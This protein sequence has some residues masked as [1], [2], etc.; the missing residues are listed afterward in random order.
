MLFHGAR[1]ILLRRIQSLR[2]LLNTVLQKDINKRMDLTWNCY[3]LSLTIDCRVGEMV[4]PYPVALP[5]MS[6]YFTTSIYNSASHVSNTGRHLTYRQ[7]NVES[8]SARRRRD[9]SH[10]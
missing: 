2:I 7:E 5:P 6:P 1:R 3:L 9:L 10:H 4:K 8:Q